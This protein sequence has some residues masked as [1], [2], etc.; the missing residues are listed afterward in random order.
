VFGCQLILSLFHWDGLVIFG[1]LSG[2]GIRHGFV[3]QPLTYMFLHAGLFHLLCNLLGLWFLGQEVEL[4][5]GRKHFTW[6]YLLGGLAGAG[7]WLFFNFRAGFVIGASAAVLAVVIAFATLFPDRELTFLLWFI[8]PVRLKAKYIALF[9]IVL[10]IVP[11]LEQAHSQVAHL[12]HLGGAALGYF[13]IKQL[14]YGRPPWW[15][16]LTLRRRPPRS[17]PDYV[18]EKVDPI[19]DKISRDGMQSLTAEE[20]RILESARDYI[21]RPRS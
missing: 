12:A 13:Y 4:F 11:L 20:R 14:G 15:Q 9:L 21:A 2:A 19:L 18:R 5:I 16:R 7:L 3:W 1:A 17:R 10:D 6:L 8:I